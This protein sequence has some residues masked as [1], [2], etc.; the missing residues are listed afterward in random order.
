MAKPLIVCRD[1]SIIYNKGKS[2]EFK[3][4]QNVNTDIYEG[5][6]IILFGASGSGKSTLMYSIQG[7]LPPGDGTLLIRG[8]DIYSYPP[9]ERVYF[10][11]YV[12]GIIFQSFNLIGS[13]SV[14]D[15][16]ALPMI[17]CDADRTTRER[18]AQSLLDRFGV[19]HVSHKIPAMLSGG[20]Q[21]RVS[22]SRSMVNDP[23]ITTCDVATVWTDVDSAADGWNMF[24]STYLTNGESTTNIA[25]SDG[26]VSDGA[27]VFV[28]GNAGVR[29]TES[30]TASTTIP[31]SDY[32]DL[33][34][35]IT[36]TDFTSFSTTY[37]FRVSASGVP[38]GQ[39]SNFAELTTA[40]KRDFKIQRGS[41][42]VSGTS[43][44]V[45]AGADYVAPLNPSLAF[46]RITNAHFTGAGN[47][48]ATAG[49]NADDV[50]AFIQNP[51]NLATS[52][53][54]ARPPAALS[55]T[56]VDW[57][58]IEFIG[59]SDTDNEMIVRDVGTVSFTTTSVV[60]SGPAVT[61]IGDDSKVV[62]FVTGAVNRNAS[63]NFY[64]SQVTSAWD[65]GSDTPVF[66]RGANGASIAEVS[67]AVV[68]FVGSNWNV[69]RAEHS[70]TA[71]GVVETESI[72]AVNSLARTFLHAQKRMG[73]TTN[74]V[75][76]GHEVW[77]SSIGAIS[78]QLETGATLAVEQT[79]VVWVVEN[80]Q[81][82]A[83]AMSIQRS[84]G[85][86]SGGTGPLAL[87]VILPSPIAALNNTSIMANTRAAGANTTYP[88][89][90]AGFTITSTS[91]Y[92]IWRSNTGSALTYRVE[93]VEWPVADLSIRQ[94]YYRFY[95][96]NNSLTPTDAW[97]PGINDLG[98]NTSLTIADEPLGVG[99][100]LRIRMTLRVSN[101]SMPA[102]LQNFKLQY[103]LRATTCSAISGGS[104]SDVGAAGSGLVWRGY[105][106]TGTT[107]GAV[108]ST[109]PPTNGDLLIS[110]ADRAG[111]LVHQNPSAVNPYP[112][113][114][115]DNIEYDWYLE[116]NGANPQSTYC[117]RIVRSDGTVLE[118][119]SNYPQIR[120]AGFTPLIKN[121][122]WY[123]DSENE[124]P[125]SALA[126]ENVTPIDV[127][128]TDTLALRV[129][130]EERRNA[131]GDNI[132]FKLQFSDDIT[133]AN[134]I[135][136]VSTSSC[137]ERSLWCYE[138]G[139]GID[140]TL[141]STQVL[142][143][144]DGC[145]ASVG[146]GCGRHNTAPGY[147]EGHTHFGS[148]TQEYAFTIRNVAARV[149]A[150]Y[151]FRLYDVT[152][153]SPVNFAVGNS[154]PSVVTEGPFL[155]FE[156]SGLPSGTTTAGVVTDV[157]TSPTGIGFGVLA[158]GTEYIGAHRITVE[159][160]ATEGYQLFKFAR[161][162]LQSQTGVFIPPIASTNL[163]P[164]SWADACLV[165]ATGCFGYHVTDP[166]LKDGS[167][168][169]AATDTY[170]ALETTPV[171]VMYSGIP[172]IDTHDIVYRI[173]VNQM[174]PAGTYETEIV[175]LAVPSY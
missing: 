151:Y 31:V 64:A 18:R 78:F 10:Q 22:V 38:L 128:N 50:T 61:G 92:Q 51:G 68:E 30:V 165:S 21:Q 49:Q 23:K 52:F 32:L 170:A 132:K 42:Q 87:S 88:R 81:P 175:Y 116:H 105:A 120:T 108:L 130:V 24:D 12:M 59:K 39:Y 115:G 4:L 100:R 66:T 1:L 174:Q 96:D 36:S 164:D 134:P 141:I 150:V 138:E 8:D 160:N 34:F 124:T 171:E 159:S 9:S 45:T 44:V 106:A 172:S 146:A 167:T 133:F 121:W 35:S 16:V 126:P 173:R 91:T 102:G 53:T 142:S 161:T 71:D 131:Q 79:S 80:L 55:N 46:V 112:V 19:G 152:N 25:V 157:P 28:S 136:V 145:V 76:Y 125:T 37:C 73:A 41:V 82:G 93:L 5:E 15:N 166:T 58:I 33:E 137:Q 47:T 140:N 89:P 48:A 13:L 98:E 62:V 101:A 67:Y 95:V 168:R 2:N 14:L 83:G 90:N 94:N 7:S 43:T 6:Y 144:G 103:A 60:E 56:R 54:I 156:L 11:R 40:P 84:N 110:I 147:V 26:G 97:P 111:V 117:F 3:A 77:L 20:Q 69:Q 70:Y 149:N 29:D 135:D 118:G 169:F 154:F 75:H 109:N 143:D 99:D 107:D 123:E 17:F 139:G 127:A 163:I 148:V 27:G 65:A 114:E 119:Y 86:T 104:W 162:Q 155:Q 74:V 113:D 63:R 57:E 122:R 72:T 158:L 85:L 153:E 129:S